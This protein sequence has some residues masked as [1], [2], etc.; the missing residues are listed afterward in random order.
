MVHHAGIVPC[1]RVV[2][3]IGQLRIEPYVQR[4]RRGEI[5]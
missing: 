5:R 4:G 2:S 1:H 3:M